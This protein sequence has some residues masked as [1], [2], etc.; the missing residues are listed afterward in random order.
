MLVVLEA[1]R[2]TIGWTLPLLSVAF[3]AYAWLG[4]DLPAWLL[5][6]RGY[7][8]P[9]I[10]AQVFL[11]GQGVF[12]VALSVMFTYVFLFLLFGAFLEATGATGFLSTRP[13]GCSGRA[14]GG[15]PRWPW[16][17]ARSWGRSPAAPSPTP[18]P[19]APSPS[20]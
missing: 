2:R 5:P 1:T 10:A 7:D 11:H 14:A 16:C 18:P 12:G 13:S 4:S 15:R 3:V 19:P 17:R 20:R 8:L 6:H 9:R